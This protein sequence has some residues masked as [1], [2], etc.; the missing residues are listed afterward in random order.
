MHCQSCAIHTDRYLLHLETI[1]YTYTVFLLLFTFY[2]QVVFVVMYGFWSY[3][4]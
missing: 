2:V 1:I 4:Q 3:L